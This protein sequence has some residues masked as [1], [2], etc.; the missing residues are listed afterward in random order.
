M[1]PP[2]TSSR[3]DSIDTQK[4]PSLISQFCLGYTQ[5]KSCED[6]MAFLERCAVFICKDLL[7]RYIIP[8][9]TYLLSIGKYRIAMFSRE[10]VGTG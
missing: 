4:D 6:L 7:H 9:D 3:G 1:T 8:I 2:P 10:K 5:K